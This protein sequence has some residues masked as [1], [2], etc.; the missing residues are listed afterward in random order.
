MI[1][2]L[3]GTVAPSHSARRGPD[4][5]FWVNR[6]YVFLNPD[7]RG[8]YKSQGNISYWGRQLAEDG[9]DFIEWAAQQPWCSGKVGMA[10]NSWLAVSQWF[11]AAEQPPHLTAIAPWE[12]FVDHFRET[13]NRGGIP[14]PAFPEVILK[15]FAGEH[16]VEDQ[17]RMI[18]EKQ[19][20]D[21]YWED[22]IARLEQINIPAYVVASYTNH[23]HTHGSFAGYRQIASKAK[24]LRVN[25]TNEWLDF[26]TP[27]YTNELL[28][29][30]DHYLKGKENGWGN[31][32]QVRICILD[33]GGT[34]TVDRVEQC[35]PP[36]KTKLK[37]MF[38]SGPSQLATAHQPETSSLSYEVSGKGNIELH[39]I[40]SEETEI[41]GYMKVKLWVEA[42]GADDMELEVGIEKRD[43]HGTPH[44]RLLGE[45]IKDPVVASGMLRVSQRALD[46]SRSTE[47]EPF[48]L[49]TREDKLHPGEIVPIEVGIWPMAMRY[50]ATECHPGVTQGWSSEVHP[51][52]HSPMTSG[53]GD[54]VGNDP[55]VIGY[56][57][58]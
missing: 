7:P 50:H 45:G 40:F 2:F 22:K 41:T 1:P 46:P 5:A 21:P 20:I 15:T 11:I 18:S 9:Y 43:R 17:P 19:L 34:D 55:V 25:N 3:S 23:A 35:W 30:F 49:H 10:G 13:G 8:V 27:K 32:P 57:T 48:L 31:T 38:I 29:F 51:F 14:A 36:L 16:L 44:E 28:A 24:W 56:E 53:R 12:G 26:Y 4:P 58:A 42:R 6:G 47:E 39:Y 52:R 37:K 33:E 54:R